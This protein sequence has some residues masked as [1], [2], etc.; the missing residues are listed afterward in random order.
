MS[1]G[2]QQAVLPLQGNVVFKVELSE[3]QLECYVSSAVKKV[4]KQLLE[5]EY[6][7]V[8]FRTLTRSYLG[9]VPAETTELTAELYNP[10]LEQ[11][12][13]AVIEEL[14][15]IAKK[16][17]PQVAKAEFD[18]NSAKNF[19]VVLCRVLDRM[20]REALKNSL[21]CEQQTVFPLQGNIVFP[22]GLSRGTL[23]SYV[24]PVVEVYL[25]QKLEEGYP[26]VQFETLTRQWSNDTKLTAKVF[27]PE[28]TFEQLRQAV[29]E[30]VTETANQ[31]PSSDEISS[32]DTFNNNF[33]YVLGRTFDRMFSKAL[34]KE[35]L[36]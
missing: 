5:K 8:L 23:E 16:Q 32:D 14:T 20:F 19:K 21:A 12:E 9:G 13:Q 4:L 27:N 3:D 25:R 10:Y 33:R 17:V 22:E 11:L 29:I 18:D 24:S 15:E 2:E 36:S 31:V 6:P 7:I 30:K 34:E 1:N 28:H 26:I 35:L